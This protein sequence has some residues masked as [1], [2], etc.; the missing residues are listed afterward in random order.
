MLYKQNSVIALLSTIKISP[1]SKEPPNP[2]EDIDANLSIFLEYFNANLDILTD[3]MEDKLA[4]IIIQ[5]IWNRIVRDIESL[6]V[7]SLHLETSE[8]PIDEKQ[9]AIIQYCFTV[10]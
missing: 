7:P 8:K 5:S 9:I 4:F 1:S 3:I 6:L 2:E 10:S